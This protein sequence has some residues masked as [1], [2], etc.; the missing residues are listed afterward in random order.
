MMTARSFSKRWGI[1]D[2]KSENLERLKNRLI[3]L[4]GTEPAISKEVHTKVAFRLGM[5]LHD[6]GY[7]QNYY[8]YDTV[9]RFEDL[10]STHNIPRLALHLE[11]FMDETAFSQST[12]SSIA[13]LVNA[14]RVGI[15]LARKG[16]SWFSYP[17]GEELL[18]ATLVERPLNSLGEASSAEFTK[19]LQYFKDGKWDTAV[20]KTRRTLE[21]YIREKMGNK[22]GLQANILVLMKSIKQ[23]EVPEHLRTIIQ[24]HLVMLDDY[25]N[26]ASKHETKVGGT[27]ECEFTIYATGTI[28]NLLDQIAINDAGEKSNGHNA[29]A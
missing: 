22:K 8:P 24:R 23:Q 29:P 12:C 13:K 26:H 27:A 21:E 5:P 16:D 20:E 9:L 10:I 7:T 17:E 3:L 11:T 6:V 25:Y 19:A 2:N 15:R 4:L 1:E 14:S 18:D 28:I